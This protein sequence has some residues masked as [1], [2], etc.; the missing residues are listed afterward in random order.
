MLPIERSIQF[1]G[2]WFLILRRTLTPKR[3]PLSILERLHWE[4]PN[5]SPNPKLSALD[6]GPSRSLEVDL[7]F[8][9]I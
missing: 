2:Q 6:S 1:N 8:L 9:S 5:P 3:L 4:N 7:A